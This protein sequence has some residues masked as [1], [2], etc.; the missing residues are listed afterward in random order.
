MAYCHC[1]N[2]IEKREIVDFLSIMEKEADT[3]S[4]KEK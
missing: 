2:E 4:W 1:E 3:V